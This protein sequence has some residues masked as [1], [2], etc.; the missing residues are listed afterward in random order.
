V[1]IKKI[2]GAVQ[3]ESGNRARLTRP[4]VAFAFPSR[5][6]PCSISRHLVMDFQIVNWQSAIEN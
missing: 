1:K 5:S 4:R 3:A 2:K 6:D